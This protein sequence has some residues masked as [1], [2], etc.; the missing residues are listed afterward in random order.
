M[1]P[2]RTSDSAE[3]VE[4]FGGQQRRRQLTDELLEQRR[5][6][7]R[8]DLVPVE[9]TAVKRVLQLLLQDLRGTRAPRVRNRK[10][11]KN[12]FVYYNIFYVTLI[13]A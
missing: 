7:V 8:T 1:R 6:V 10:S 9:R 13:L 5:G 2:S 4:V 12:L 3:G 11:K